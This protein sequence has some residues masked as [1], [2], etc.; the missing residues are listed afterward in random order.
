M[1]EAWRREN[2]KMVAL[3]EL[4]DVRIVDAA[5]IE[6]C[7]MTQLLVW[8]KNALRKVAARGVNV[9][10]LVRMDGDPNRQRT[11]VCGDRKERAFVRQDGVRCNFKI[12]VLERGKKLTLLS[13]ALH[14][15]AP[16]EHRAPTFL[17]WEFE[18][19]R[20]AGVDAIKEPLAHLHPG[21]DAVRVPSPVLSPKELILLLLGTDLWR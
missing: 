9:D 18:Q 2:P 10:S 6:E 11:L 12:N 19:S 7:N 17:R 13:Y 16:T 4:R 5:P 15:D 8:T 14:L 21:H 1:N 20:K 3:A